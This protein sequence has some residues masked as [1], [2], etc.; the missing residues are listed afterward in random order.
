MIHSICINSAV[1]FFWT[2]VFG[3][4]RIK[5]NLIRDMLNNFLGNT[6]QRLCV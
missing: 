2:N 3:E 5:E 1:D 6:R 4:G